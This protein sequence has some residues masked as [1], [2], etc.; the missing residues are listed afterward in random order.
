MFTR[1]FDAMPAAGRLCEFL[2]RLGVT[3]GRPTE[4]KVLTRLLKFRD[5]SIDTAMLAG[6]MEFAPGA[7]VVNCGIW[8]SGAAVEQMSRFRKELGLRYVGHHL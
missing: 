3:A 5:H 8:W 2:R 4:G 7:M 1:N 6:P